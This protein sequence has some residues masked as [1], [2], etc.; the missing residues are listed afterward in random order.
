MNEGSVFIYLVEALAGAVILLLPHFAPRQYFFAVTVP[1]GFRDSEAGRASLRRYYTWACAALALCWAAGQFLFPRA[2]GVG[3]A[4]GIAMIAALAA[5]VRERSH[6]LTIVRPPRPA[7]SIGAPSADHLPRWFPLSLGPFLLLLAAA[8]YL[9][10]HW[11]EIPARFPVHW[12]AAGQPDRWVDKSASGVFGPLLFGAGLLLLLLMLALGVFYGSRR[13][14]QRVVVL[15]ILVALMYTLCFVFGGVALLP[16]THLSPVWLIIPIPLVTIAIV[17]WSFQ[18]VRDPSH[19]AEATP[20]E[21]WRLGLLYYNPR[22]PALF[23]Q[24][25]VGFGYT[26][27]FGNRIAWVIFGSFLIGLIALIYTL[28]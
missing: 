28:P 17:V 22:D 5:F 10:A 11:N 15:K 8:R 12:G 9:R 7:A 2:W 1:A 25:R 23:V 27:N 18:Y 3:A 14:P 16:V 21:C 26:F 19:P 20:D 4:V 6:I 24:K 13:A